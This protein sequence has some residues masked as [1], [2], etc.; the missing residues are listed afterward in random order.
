M[1]KLIFTLIA[2]AV[3]QFAFSQ[4]TYYWVGGAAPSLTSFNTAAY[5]NTIPGGGGSSRSTPA[6]TDIL[7]IDGTDISDAAGVQ[8]GPIVFAF[9]SPTAGT[10]P[11]Q[12]KIQGGADVTFKRTNSA[13]TST[14]TIGNGNAVDN[15]P[16]F[17]VAAGSKFTIAGTGGSLLV[18]LD[19]NATAEISGDVA[20]TEGNS[21][22]QNRFT[23]KTSGSFHFLSGSTFTSAATYAY[24]PF[25]TTGSATTPATNGVIFESGSSYYYYG[26]NSPFGSNSSSFLAVFKPGSKFYF[27]GSP[28][29]NMFTNRSYADVVIDNNATVTADGSLIRIDSLRV[30]SGATFI[31]HTS[32]TTPIHGNIVVNGTLRVPAAN[33][34]RDNRII[35]A[36]SSPQ[37]I[38]GTGT[39]SLADLIISDV[40]VATLQQDI[41]V[42]S[43][44]RVIGQFNPGGKT[45]SGGGTISTKAAA[46]PGYVVT[47][48]TNI[49]SFL[50]KNVSDLTNVEYGMSVSGTGIQANTV[51]VNYSSTNNTITLSKPVTSATT[52]AGS[53]AS[54][55]VFNGQ[56]QV[57]PVKLTAFNAAYIENRVKLQWSVSTED[58]LA[59]Y[60]VERSADGKQFS[61]IGRVVAVKQASYE[62]YDR[63]PISGA[64]YYRLKE[65]DNNGKFSY[66]NIVKISTAAGKSEISVSPNPLAGRVFSLAMNN[67][68]AGEY[69]L[70]V[71]NSNGQKVAMKSLGAVPQHFT[72]SI[73]LPA[74]IAKGIYTVVVSGNQQW[75]TTRLMIQ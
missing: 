1:K 23:A 4:T 13:G 72:T 5:W 26:G 52:Y 44:L 2:S 19:V 68:S 58:N 27:R 45:I 33:P 70:T 75:L 10:G 12:L 25:S 38:G 67:L 34:D 22:Q 18:L 59:G 50:V 47:G 64:N 60:E 32:G 49:D 20:I 42:D 15:D 41:Q 54:L 46:N 43:V 36:G 24:Y 6:V 9:S 65:T 14:L 7:I 74:G 56:G 8:T 31:T 3:A 55:T 51:I 29:A 62:F 61:S 40:S 37:S 28:A 11:A 63:Q 16:D 39:Y 66:S 21:S 71:L 73:E 57:L 48:N 53:A 30:E 69:T 17:V 35:I